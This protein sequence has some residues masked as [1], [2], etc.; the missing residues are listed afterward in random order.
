MD[1]SRK[2]V[3]F[4][5]DFSDVMCCSVQSEVC[6]FKKTLQS[7][8]GDGWNQLLNAYPGLKNDF[9]FML[10]PLSIAI[11]QDIQLSENSTF[12]VQVLMTGSRL[13]EKL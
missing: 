8:D 3:N 7:Y 11:V 4:P 13:I 12:A 9:M 2:L 1:I 5:G 6:I 10:S